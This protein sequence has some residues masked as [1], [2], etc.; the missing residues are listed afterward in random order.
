MSIRALSRPGARPCPIT[1]EGL[2]CG[3][4][5]GPEGHDQLRR[6]GGLGLPLPIHESPCGKRWSGDT[7]LN[8]FGGAQRPDTSP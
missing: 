2:P 3:L 4:I 6:Y 8:S 5:F 1:F 7:L